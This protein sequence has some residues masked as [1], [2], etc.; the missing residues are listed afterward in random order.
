MTLSVHVRIY[1]NL[2]CIR[3]RYLVVIILIRLPELIY[4]IVNDLVHV[5]VCARACLCVLLFRY[6]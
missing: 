4:E 5:H 6:I 3:R 2:C 1:R